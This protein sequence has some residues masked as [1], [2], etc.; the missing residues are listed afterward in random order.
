MKQETKYKKVIQELEREF[1]VLMNNYLQKL[2]S[3]FHEDYGLK[4][5]HT[6]IINN[7]KQDCMSIFSNKLESIAF[8]N[9]SDEEVIEEILEYN[10]DMMDVEH[11]KEERVDLYPIVNQLN[12]HCLK[13]TD[14]QWFQFGIHELMQNGKVNPGNVGIKRT[15][16]CK[17]CGEAVYL[18]QDVHTSK[19]SKRLKT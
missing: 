16:F 10:F 9:R 12:E 5:P 6:D 15:Q 18:G 8:D 7:I 2:H 1:D 11:M 4:H 17:Y 14:P 13:R 3:A 19:H